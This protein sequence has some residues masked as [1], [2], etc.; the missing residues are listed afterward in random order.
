MCFSP[1]GKRVNEIFVLSPK[2]NLFYILV[3][4]YKIGYLLINWL[5]MTL[6]SLEEKPP[7]LI[8]E[9]FLKPGNFS[10]FV[11]CYVKYRY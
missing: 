8:F 10:K 7:V 6:L 11:Y 1:T 3:T 9:P 4:C 5:A 2:G